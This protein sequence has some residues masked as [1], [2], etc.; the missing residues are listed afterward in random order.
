MRYTIMIISYILRYIS[1]EEFNNIRIR[2]P[3]HNCDRIYEK[4]LTYIWP[5][6]FEE[7]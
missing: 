6:N 7:T 2:N 4:G 3:L 5:Y 1:L